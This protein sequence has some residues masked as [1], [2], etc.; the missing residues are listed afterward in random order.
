MF[1]DVAKIELKA[2]RGGDGAIAFRRE[3]FEP[4][5][6]PAGGDGGNGGSIIVKGDSGLRTLMDFRYKRHYKAESG[7]NGKNKK[8]YGKS[9]KDL[10]LKVPVGTLIKDYKSGK[11]MYD[12]KND[13]DEYIIV[14][15]G[16]GGRGNVKFATSVRQA[17]RF[18]EPGKPGDERTVLL[19][20]KLIADIGLIGMPNVGKSSLLSILSNAKP[21]IANYHFT[22]LSPN[23][24]VVEIE[25]GKSFVIA[26]IP[27]LIEGAGEGAGLGHDFLRHI[28][29]TRIL[30]HVLDISGSE[31]RDPLEDFYKINDELKEYNPELAKKKQIVI[32]NKMDIPDSELYEEIVREELEKEGYTIVETSA[33]TGE[34]VK[35]LSYKLW[36]IIE[37]TDN[38]YET[39]DE[40]YDFYE[41]EKEEDI[42][43]SVKNDI[44]HVEG[45]FID[46]LVYRTNFENY[47]A[48]NFFYNTL[49]RRGIIDQLKE[50][51]LNEGDTVVVGDMEFEFR[52]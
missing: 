49:K 3:K 14:K 46:D 26:D 51:G 11:V 7:E 50:I 44:I 13:G 38:E 47:E 18:A 27:G 5:G 34:G 48:L 35:E 45:P 28:E 21:K 9:G 25:H 52:E 24:G 23:L 32:F 40:E 29:R 10:V 37:D 15:G 1:I 4:L 2:G 39:F 36:E 20:L 31:G 33:A 16:R 43:I 8:Q 19:E 12:I 17:P 22:T 6:G 42:I 30:A 41:E